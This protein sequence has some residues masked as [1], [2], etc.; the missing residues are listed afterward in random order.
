MK[1]YFERTLSE[2]FREYYNKFK[3]ESLALKIVYILQGILYL[4]LILVYVAGIL[5]VGIIGGLQASP[6]IILKKIGRMFNKK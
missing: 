4:P 6:V 2:A 5:I 3:E 1:K